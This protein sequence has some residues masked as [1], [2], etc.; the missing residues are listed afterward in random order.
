MAA[1]TGHPFDPHSSKPLPGNVDIVYA[2][3]GRGLFPWHFG[4]VIFNY[5]PGG[6]AE[7]IYLYEEQH[8]LFLLGG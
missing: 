4:V 2:K 3:D 8:G 7:R 6:S 1:A 5:H